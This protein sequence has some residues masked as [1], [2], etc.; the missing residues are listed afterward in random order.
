M[1]FLGSKFSRF[2]LIC[3]T[4]LWNEFQENPHMTNAQ[5]AKRN[6]CDENVRHWLAR[7]ASVQ[8]KSAAN[9]LP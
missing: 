8:C 1:V 7:R 9:S 5:L 4:V 6:D 3:S 2:D